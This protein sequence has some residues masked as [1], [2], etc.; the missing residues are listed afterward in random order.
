MA[1]AHRPLVLLLALA[2]LVGAPDAF[3]KRHG[4]S[5]GHGRGHHPAW[6]QARIGA[7]GAW[8]RRATHRTAPRDRDTQVA[9]GAR[10]RRDEA[11]IRAALEA[12]RAQRRREEVAAFVA[13][14][15]PLASR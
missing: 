7:F 14:H 13:A 10:H 3:A 2:L 1:C 8:L 4:R 5:H 12:Q 15:P 11:A 6:V 9:T